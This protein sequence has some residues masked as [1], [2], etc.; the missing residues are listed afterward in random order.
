MIYVQAAKKKKYTTIRC[1]KSNNPNTDPGI[2][3]LSLIMRRKIH[4][5]L[6]D[7]RCH[8]ILSKKVSNLSITYLKK[9]TSLTKRDAT[10]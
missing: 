3:L 8:L 10:N 5:T 7:R 1:L 4:S 9:I 2:S 6:M